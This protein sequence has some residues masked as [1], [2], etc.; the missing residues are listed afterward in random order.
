MYTWLPILNSRDGS[1]LESA[2]LGIDVELQ[3]VLLKLLV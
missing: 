1:C 2:E 3:H